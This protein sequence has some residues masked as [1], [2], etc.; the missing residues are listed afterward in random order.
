MNILIVHAHNER[1]SFCSAM[2]NLAVKELGVMGHIV[3]VS[4][5][6]DMKWNPV[7]SAADFGER[8][9]PDYLV[10]ALEQ[11]HNYKRQSLAPDILAELNKLLWAD[12]VIF[13][14]PIYWFSLPAILKG[15][16]DRVFVS[17]VVYGGK[18]FYD[19]GGLVGKKSMLSIT[20][21][22]QHH[23]LTGG[24]VHGPLQEMLRP[25]LRGT[26]AYTGMSVLPPFVGLH[27][28][29]ITNEERV[30]ILDE[31]RNRLYSLD[32]L[33]PLEFVSLNQFDDNL[34]PLIEV[35]HI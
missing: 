20:I 9:N 26:L 19:R 23:M 21:G 27:V 24:G 8:A 10:Y 33:E 28:P 17:G 22:G 34:N 3:Q 1:N 25:I 13:N 15:W 6:Y 11:R 16:I 29:Y 4:D 30:A 32:A 18:R 7:A 2:K 35:P 14:F 12:M 31:Y 5:L